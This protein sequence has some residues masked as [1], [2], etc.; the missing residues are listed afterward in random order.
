MCAACEPLHYNIYCYESLYLWELHTS[1]HGWHWLAGTSSNEIWMNQKMFDIFCIDLSN[2]ILKFFPETFHDQKKLFDFIS[3]KNALVQSF[4]WSTQAQIQIHCFVYVLCI[5][6]HV[7]CIMHNSIV[8][9]K[10]PI[11]IAALNQF[12]CLIYVKEPFLLLHQ[13]CGCVS[14]MPYMS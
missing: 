11:F 12:M 7:S 6:Y 10:S 2:Y 8:M 13:K 5:M 4:I 1:S 3:S 14:D 9:L